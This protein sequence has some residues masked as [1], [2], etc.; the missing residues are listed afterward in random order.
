MRIALI[1][2]LPAKDAAGLCY[3]RLDLPLE[4]PLDHLE[5]QRLRD[6]LPQGA[7]LYSSPSL[8][9]WQLAQALDDAAIADQ[10]LQE[11][12]F[13]RWEGRAWQ[14]IGAAAL[15]AWIVSGYAAIHG[16]ESLLAMQARVWQWADE[17]A[18]TGRDEVIA[19]THA[20]VIRALW[21]RTR[22]WEACLAQPVPFG[23]VQWLD[24]PGRS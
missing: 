23:E 7:P 15:D 12:D 11:L 17:L 6:T 18:A 20:G 5:T 4:R 1:R 14:D 24:W 21:S 8:R 9:C 3:G 19:V 13:G 16:G 2:H 22:S 10:R